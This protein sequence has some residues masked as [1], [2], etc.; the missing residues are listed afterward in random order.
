MWVAIEDLKITCTSSP[1]CLGSREKYLQLIN[2]N[3]HKEEFAEIQREHTALAFSPHDF[4][5]SQPFVFKHDF[6]DIFT[7]S[8]FFFFLLFERK[9]AIWLILLSTSDVKVCLEPPLRCTAAQAE[10]EVPG[11]RQEEHAVML[12]LPPLS[13]ASHRPSYQGINREVTELF[14]MWVCQDQIVIPR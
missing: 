3:L 5:N 2:F 11:L 1:F 12:P 10:Q 9:K 7:A 6:F 14:S 4:S 13:S 8:R